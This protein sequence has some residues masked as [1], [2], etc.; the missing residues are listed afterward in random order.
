MKGGDDGMKKFT[1]MALV[2]FVLIC[3]KSWA[4]DLPLPSE[5]P[6]QVSGVVFDGEKLVWDSNIEIDLAGYLV[7]YTD[8]VEQ[9]VPYSYDEN[10]IIDVG[11][12]TEFLIVSLPESV[13]VAGAYINFV[14]YAY[15][16][17]DNI[18]ERSI[19]EVQVAA[20]QDFPPVPPTGLEKL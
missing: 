4:I 5:P 19:E 10:K 2:A 16:L 14:V 8:S 11:N 7:G 9:S 17:N 15:D 6:I 12:V 18:S 20:T 13:K 3:G 1:L